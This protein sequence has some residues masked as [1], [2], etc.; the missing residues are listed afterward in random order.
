MMIMSPL[1]LITSEAAFEKDNLIALLSEKC[2][3]RVGQLLVH[4]GWV[5]TCL[6]V[7]L[8]DGPP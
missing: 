2:N 7:S 3:Y 8:A 4:L 1:P 6:G 5:D